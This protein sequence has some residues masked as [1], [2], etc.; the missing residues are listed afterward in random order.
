MTNHLNY[1]GFHFNQLTNYYVADTSIK[2]N[3]QNYS[4]LGNFLTTLMTLWCF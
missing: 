1:C 2:L 3:Y 4:R